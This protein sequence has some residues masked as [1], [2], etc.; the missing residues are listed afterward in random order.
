[1]LKKLMFNSSKNKIIMKKKMVIAAI[2]AVVA[3]GAAWNLGQARESDALSDISLANIEALALE[4]EALSGRICSNQMAKGPYLI[5]KCGPPCRE[6]LACDWW[7]ND[8]CS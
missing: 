4:G 1:M 8:R 3:V 7:N 5:I 6:V 2:A